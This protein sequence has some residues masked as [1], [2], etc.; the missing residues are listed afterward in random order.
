M[1]FPTWLESVVVFFCFTM[2]VS[3]KIVLSSGLMNYTMFGKSSEN[4]A[5][6]IAHKD[7]HFCAFWETGFSL[8][9]KITPVLNRVC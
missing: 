5:Q 4:Q 9:L 2:K 7:V 6:K 8:L 3:Q 1:L